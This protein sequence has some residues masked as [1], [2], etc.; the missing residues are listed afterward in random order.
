MKLKTFIL[1]LFLFS[2]PFILLF[3]LYIYLDPFKVI[4]H[5]DSYYISG[6]PSYISLNKDFISTENWINRHEK[7]QY[8]SFILGNSRSMFYEI[9]TWKNFVNEPREKC[10]HFDASGES[11]F[12]IERKL[13]F[14]AEK[15]A[16]LKN[17]LLVIDDQLLNQAENS[18]GHLFLKH[19]ALTGENKYT[20]QLE[21][22]KAFFDFKFLRSYLDFTFSGKVKDYMK[23]EFLLDDRPFFYDSVTNEVQQKYFEEKIKANPDDFYVPIKNIFYDRDTITQIFAPQVIKEKQ[24]ALLQSIKKIF[25]KGNTSYRIIISPNYDQKKLNP[26]DLRILKDIFG[27]S[28]VFDFSGINKYT[29]NYRNYYETSHYR[30]PVSNELMRIAYSQK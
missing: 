26:T 1:K 20:I 12:G 14:L 15:Q 10:Y 28:N 2:I 17:V 5:Y 21:S 13:N 18:K 27:E 11:I 22:L 9:D 4:R 29:N 16:P 19:P 25:T 23:K 3:S 24:L 30:P 6:K 8:N 7:H